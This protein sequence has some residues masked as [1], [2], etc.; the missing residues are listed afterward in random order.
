LR[1]ADDS[2]PRAWPPLEALGAASARST[3]HHQS[4]ESACPLESALRLAVGVRPSFGL[5]ACDKRLAIEHETLIPHRL[6]IPGPRVGRLPGMGV[7]ARCLSA[8]V[9][10]PDPALL[11]LRVCPS[12][13]LLACDKRLAI[14]HETLVPHRLGIP[15][16]G[17]GWLPGMGV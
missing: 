4:R 12:F 14:E 5:L 3:T 6:G 10:A 2:P 13:G 11:V 7:H 15:G 16:L 9:K 1:R 17:V 8:L